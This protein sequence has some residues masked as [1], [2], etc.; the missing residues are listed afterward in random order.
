VDVVDYLDLPIPE[1]AGWNEGLTFD[2]ALRALRILLATPKLAGL[3]V[4]EVNPDHDPDGSAT[5][6]LVEALAT[7]LG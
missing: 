2:A 4:T 7:A 5:E 1:N 6:R 3:T